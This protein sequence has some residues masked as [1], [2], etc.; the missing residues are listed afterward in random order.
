M[1]RFF[2]MMPSKEIEKSKTF[3]DKNGLKAYIDA[4]KN[5]W[6]VRYADQSSQFEDVEATTEDNFNAALETLKSEIP[7][8][9]ECA[10]EE[11]EDEVGDDAR[12][13]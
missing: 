2:G 12:E 13:C 10:S 9:A 3:V 5:G 6:T 8:M 7:S 1:E 11:A 4:G